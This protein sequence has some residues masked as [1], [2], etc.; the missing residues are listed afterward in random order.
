MA[1]VHDD[2]IPNAA[3]DIEPAVGIEV[4]AARSIQ[5]TGR[6]RDVDE[7]AGLGVVA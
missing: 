6:D 2:L 3:A 5:A 7:L 4:Q 1:A